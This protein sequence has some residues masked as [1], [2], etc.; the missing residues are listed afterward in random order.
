MK[1]RWW[2]DGICEERFQFLLAAFETDHLGVDRLCGSALQDQV[3]R[4][5]AVRRYSARFI[6]APPSHRQMTG[7]AQMPAA[8]LDEE[9]IALRRPDGREMP[10]GPDGEAEQP[11]AQTEAAG[12]RS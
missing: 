10:D 2:L 9:R 8:H 6:I 3:Q 4:R 12:R 1:L 5:V 11:Q 7:D